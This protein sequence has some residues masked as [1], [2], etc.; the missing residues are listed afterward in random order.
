MD[1]TESEQIEK[2]VCSKYKCVDKTYD[3]KTL[4]IN[5]DH[6]DSYPDN[7]FD[8]LSDAVER[9]GFVAFT[10]KGNPDSIVILDKPPNRKSDSTVKIALVVA[11]ILSIIYVG[12]TYTSAF[13]GG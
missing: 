13:I 8:N 12:Y 1:K 11:T 3:G 5:I 6:L 9:M 10:V 4:T 7:V 2:L